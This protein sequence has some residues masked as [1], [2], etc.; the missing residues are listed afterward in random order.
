[1]YAAYKSVVLPP[2][3]KLRNVVRL[4]LSGLSTTTHFLV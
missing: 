3:Y 1:M 4:P 2:I